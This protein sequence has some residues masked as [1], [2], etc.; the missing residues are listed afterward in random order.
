MT[1]TVQTPPPPVEREPWLHRLHPVYR[2]ILRWGYL[3]IVTV[4]AFHKSLLS[5]VETTRSGGLGGYVWVVP[6]AAILAAIGV[7]RRKRTELPIH[8]RQTDVIVGTMGLVLALLLHGVLLQRYALYFNLLRLDLVAMWTFVLS[9]S[10]ALFGLRPVIRFAWVWVVLFMVFPLP[11][12]VLVVALGGGNVAAG[13]G[14]MSIAA[15]ATGVAVGRRVR[16]G[17]IGSISA[18]AVGLLILAGMAVFTPDA[19]LLAYQVIPAIT[20]MCLVGL[21]LFLLARRGAPKRVLERKIEPLAAGQVWA[22][23]PVVLVVAIAISL[24]RLPSVGFAP[25]AVVDGMRFDTALTPP[26]GWQVHDTKEYPWVSRLFGHGATGVRQKMV[27]E[28]GDER[29]DKFGRPRTVMVD[30]LTTYWPFSLN[31][32]PARIVYHV[33]GIRLSAIRPVD[34]GYGVKADIVSVIDDKLLVTWDAI[35]WTWTND[36]VAQ[37][38]SVVAVDNHEDDAPFPAPSGIRDRRST[39]CSTCCSGATQR[40][41]AQTRTSRTTSCSPSSRTG[42]YGPNSNRSGSSRDG[43]AMAGRGRDRQR[44]GEGVR[45]R[46]GDQRIAQRAPAAV[47][48]TGR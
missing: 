1:A 30:A 39:R 6:V 40:P 36:Q 19:P 31:V 7:A 42:W 18:W 14:T 11:Y 17:L 9:G 27:A 21:I 13:I 28:V 4:V 32:Y 35:Q 8:D 23:L 46:P 43:G 5:V 29:F 45:P 25:A 38:V 2:L 34:L 12:Y 22:A 37:R 10:I 33:E 16:R 15:V 24:V 48:C 44:R 47:R 26:S 41:T 3:A 20:A